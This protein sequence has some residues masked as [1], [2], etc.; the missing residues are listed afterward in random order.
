MPTSPYSQHKSAAER[1][2][3]AAQSVEGSTLTVTRMRPGFVL[4]PAA[5][6]LLRYGLPGYVPAAALAAAASPRPQPAH[7]GDPRRRRGRGHRSRHAPPH[8]GCLQP[9]CRAAADPR[10]CCR[11][12]RCASGAGARASAQRTRGSHLAR[13]AAGSGARLGRPGLAGASAGL[14]SGQATS[15]MGSDSGRPHRVGRLHRRRAGGRPHGQP[16]RCVPGRRGI[17]YA[18]CCASDR[19]AIAT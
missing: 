4:Q 16:P 13:P 6:G 8:R 7:S 1:L 12:A 11:G 17:C 19:S 5:S 15:G 18:A 3:D 2:L 14:H 10:G 9:R